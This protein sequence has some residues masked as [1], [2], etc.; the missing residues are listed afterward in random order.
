MKLCLTCTNGGHLIE[1]LQLMEAFEGHDY[2]F[3]TL[4]AEDTKDLS[5]AYRLRKFQSVPLTLICTCLFSWWILLKERPNV[6]ISTGATF[7]VPFCY[8]GKLF[9][10]KIIFIETFTKIHSKSGAGRRVY[11]IADL[12]LV[13]WEE[14]LSVYGEK[15]RFW[16]GVI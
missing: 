13:Q 11:P 10:M 6:I 16:G 2:F 1:M 12:F 14:M 15:A 4:N 7:T 8:V 3:V 9:G 5:P